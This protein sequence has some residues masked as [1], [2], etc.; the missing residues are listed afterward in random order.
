MSHTRQY[1]GS[2]VS[3]RLLLW[4]LGYY[5]VVNIVIRPQSGWSRG[6]I[7]IR[8][9]DIFGTSRQAPRPIQPPNRWV[10]RGGGFPRG[11][12]GRGLKLTTH[13][14]LRAEIK[15]EWSYAFT[16]WTGNLPPYLKSASLM[17][18]WLTCSYSQTKAQI[19]DAVL[20]YSPT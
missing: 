16:P 18:F 11:E 8:A 5:G 17:H 19:W 6:R 14:H 2:I 3:L 1:A 10:T 12:N 4:K 20:Q 9:R 15:N 7:P 13:L